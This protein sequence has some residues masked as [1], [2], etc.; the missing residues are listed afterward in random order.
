MKDITLN[1]EQQ[2]CLDKTSALFGSSDPSVAIIRGHAGTGKSTMMA[3]LNQ[4]A[5]SE[6]FKTRFVAPTNSAAMNLRDRIGVPCD[7][8]HSA[9]YKPVVKKDLVVF[10]PRSAMV[11]DKVLWMVDEASMVPNGFSGVGFQTP[12][13]V[14]RDL[15]AHIQKHAKVPKVVFVGDAFQLPPVNEDRSAALMPEVVSRLWGGDS[16][17]VVSELTEVMRQAEDSPIRDMTSKAIGLMRSGADYD[18][19]SSGQQVGMP[20][21]WDVNRAITETASRA[22]EGPMLNTVSIVFSNKEATFMNGQVRSMMDREEGVLSAG[23]HLITDQ[24]SMVEGEVVAK[25]TRMV[26]VDVVEQVHQWGG[27]RFQG[28][29]LLTELSPDPIRIL[30][31]L[32]VLFSEKGVIGPEAEKK[33]KE[34]AMRSN[35]QYRTY[36]NAADDEHMNALRARFAYSMTAHKAQ[37]REFDRVYIKP[38]WSRSNPHFQNW[39]WFYTAMTRARQEVSTIHFYAA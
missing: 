35:T 38:I 23:D 5:Q 29:V 26:V 22:P 16:Q 2:R 12:T 25:G 10:E 36:Q 34:E 9:I 7:T 27:C 31:N 30:V 21:E 3:Q 20:R 37:G 19:R 14:L 18:W 39:Q 4:R 24:S 8:I 28:A 11:Q 32:D 1:E 6:G 17:V 33:L 13:T 15:V